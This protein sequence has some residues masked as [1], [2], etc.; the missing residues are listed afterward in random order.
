MSDSM[1]TVHFDPPRRCRQVK[2]SWLITADG[3]PDLF[4]PRLQTAMRAM[5]DSEDSVG[6][7][8]VPEYIARDRDFGSA[9]TDIVPQRHEMPGSMTR[10]DWFLLGITMAMLIRGDSVRD[11]IWEAEKTVARMEE[12]CQR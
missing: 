5:T 2:N 7:V 1:V 4:L 6:T 10:Q 9:T 3:E 12:S 8:S 11:A